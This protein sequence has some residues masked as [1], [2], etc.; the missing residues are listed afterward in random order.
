MR[1]HVR[2]VY[3]CAYTQVWT[4]REAEA[5]ARRDR[6]AQR[7][8]RLTSAGR[9]EMLDEHSRLLRDA[10]QAGRT[11]QGMKAKLQERSQEL[12]RALLRDTLTFQLWTSDARRTAQLI[13][14]AHATHELQLSR[15]L[16]MVGAAEARQ[17]AVAVQ[18]R[19]Q[20]MREGEAVAA[21][22]GNEM[23]N[24]ERQ[25]AWA[26]VKA[27]LG[28]RQTTLLLRMSHAWRAW[29]L[30]ASLPVREAR[31]ALAALSLRQQREHGVHMR[32]QAAAILTVP[33]MADL[34][35]YCCP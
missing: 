9:G 29:A 19:A 34:S 33:Y 28:V 11:V 8:E 12:E 16:E 35:V 5:E 25:R 27:V 18:T 14:D 13:K 6:T 20:A 23:E 21:A 31:G 26:A 7:A 3:V 32:L 24:L 4:I 10:A 15:Q 30:V 1:L 2:C 17:T 22:M